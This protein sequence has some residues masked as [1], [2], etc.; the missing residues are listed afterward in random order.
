MRYLLLLLIPFTTYASNWMSDAD[1][2]V[3]QAGGV[4]TKAYT[5]ER[6]C[7]HK[8]STPCHQIDGINVQTHVWGAHDVDDTEKPQFSTNPA[9]QSLN[10]P[11]PVDCPNMARAIKNA[12]ENTPGHQVEIVPGVEVRCNKVVGFDPKSVTEFHEDATLRAGYDARQAVKE[13]EAQIRA[14]RAQR[15]QDAQSSFPVTPAAKDALLKDLLD[16]ELE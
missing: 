8:E 6:V 9:D 13:A 5:S 1:R 3:V 10:I 4:G 12:C 2:L 7:N 16:R 11:C 15:L 14:D